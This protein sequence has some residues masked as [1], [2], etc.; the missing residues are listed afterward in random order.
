MRLE[1][2]TLTLFAAC[3]FIRI[4]AYVPQIYKTAT[5]KNGASAISY[6]TWGLFLVAN[7]STIAYAVVNRADWWLAVCFSC[8]A[9]CCAAIL[10]VAYW[11]ALTHARA[12]HL[13]TTSSP[14]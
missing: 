3:N 2:M 9:L 11:K 7:L 4:F 5:D 14:R 6:A 8:N 1:D 13:S 10:A 12:L